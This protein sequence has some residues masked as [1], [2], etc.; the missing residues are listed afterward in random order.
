ML[1]CF[2]WNPNPEFPSTVHLRTGFIQTRTY[3]VEVKCRRTMMAASSITSSVM[4]FPTFDL[5][6]VR[7]RLYKSCPEM[8]SGREFRV[9]ISPKTK[10]HRLEEVMCTWIMCTWRLNL[11][12]HIL[13]VHCVKGFISRS[14]YS[15]ARAAFYSSCR[16]SRMRRPHIIVMY[17]SA[18]V[19]KKTIKPKDWHRHARVWERYPS[20]P[21]VY[22]E[23]Q[24]LGYEKWMRLAV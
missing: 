18:A 20:S 11:L 17:S 4:I 13:Q 21:W 1:L 24:C 3:S 12:L 16:P 9:G 19:N 7:S 8:D 15:L 5:H 14:F 22:F 10:Q 23:H 6:A 2:R